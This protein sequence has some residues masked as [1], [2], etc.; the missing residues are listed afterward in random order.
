MYDSK[1]INITNESVDPASLCQ[2]LIVISK[3]LTLFISQ[4]FLSKIIS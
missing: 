1:P 4:K 3:D 2:L